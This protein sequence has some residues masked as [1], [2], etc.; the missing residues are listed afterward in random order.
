[1]NILHV[2]SS[3]GMYGAEAVILNLSRALNRMGHSSKIGVFAN[4]PDPN[5]HLFEAARKEGIEAYQVQCVGQV[6]LAVPGRIREL[7]RET[8]TEIVHAH[9]YKSDIYSYFARHGTAVR[10]VSTC[11]NWI[12]SNKTVRA[13]NAMDRI[14]LRSFDGVVAVSDEVRQRLM[15]SGVSS[16]RISYIRNGID[17]S[18]FEGVAPVLRQEFDWKKEMIVG[19]V[20]R[21][22][23]EKGPDI[24]LLAA[25]IVLKEVPGARFILAGDGPDRENLERMAAVHGMQDSF[26]L[27]G[28]R[29]D[30]SKIYASLDILACASR[31]EGLPMS[32][33]EGMASGCALVVTDVGDVSQLVQDGSTGR[34]ISA[35]DIQGLSAAIL[36]LLADGALRQRLAAQGKEKVRQEFSADR[37][38]SRYIEF[39]EGVLFGR[40]NGATS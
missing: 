8:N 22:S 10:L 38:A 18:L 40:A 7:V 24:F 34:L 23:K 17:T 29:S 32:I 13:Y 25:A 35:E 9:G 1:M 11:H 2:I 3:G 16:S 26:K 39:Y 37:M 20:G 30:V 31:S 36:Q 12:D 28:R 4:Q 21:L 19:Q 15:K 14:A 5:L 6:D 27:L 33:L